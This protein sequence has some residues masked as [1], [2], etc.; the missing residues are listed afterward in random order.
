MPFIT[1]D[2]IQIRADQ[3]RDI[4]N[5]LQLPQTPGPDSDWY[6]RASAV[7]GVAEGLY[8][9]QAW[10]VRQIFPDTADRD[11]MELH[12]RVRHLIRKPAVPASGPLTLT[13]NP[14]A[15][16]P[17][18]LTATLNDV[19]WT[20]TAVV[21]LD[22]AG[23][24]TV[25]AISSLP[26][27]AGDTTEP[28]AARLTTT[29]DGFDSTVIVG[30]MR[31]GTAEETDAELLARLLEL[32]RRPPAGGNQ[33]DY[34]RWALEVPGVTAAYVYPLRRGPGTVDIAITSGGSLPS[35]DTID[36]VREYID[37][38]RPVTAK[39]IMVFAPVIKLT[40]VTLQVS[41]NGITQEDAVAAIITAL[42]DDDLRREPGEPFILSQA[43]LLILL[44]PGITDVKFTSPAGN[45]EAVTDETVVE[46]LRTGTITVGLL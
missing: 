6:V 13:G 41:L 12:A 14:G 16:A 33:Y 24:G 19:S 1:P 30:V 34:K 22:A 20:T 45:V 36:R 44:I 4:L 18:G 42:H 8:Q 35:Q 17:A 43:V 15:R 10:M 11:F 37:G 5:L 23:T 25:P 29:P 28:V 9:H 38:V 31:G 40:D 39:N 21:T 32:I 46:W 7:A 26:G 2:V 27:P 3:L